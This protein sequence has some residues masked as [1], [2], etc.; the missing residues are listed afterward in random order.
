VLRK[1]HAIC[2]FL[3]DR[4]SIA[5]SVDYHAGSVLYESPSNQS[6]TATVFAATVDAFSGNESDKTWGDYA[7]GLDSAHFAARPPPLSVTVSAT[8][9]RSLLGHFLSRGVKRRDQI[10]FPSLAPFKMS[11]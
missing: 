6:V 4:M 5:T 11:T 8:L 7:A 3:T 1:K 10:R 9:S 2:G